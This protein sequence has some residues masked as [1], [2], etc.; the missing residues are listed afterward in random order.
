MG[1]TSE[2]DKAKINEKLINRIKKLEERAR[3]KR[4]V[5]KRSVIGAK[6]LCEQPF[7]LTYQSKRSGKRMWCL[8]EKRHLRIQFISFLK[9]LFY[10]ARLVRE[11]WAMGDFSLKYPLGLYPPT[12]PKLAE[13]VDLWG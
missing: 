2:E 5:E 6:R 1:I 12:V 4:V 9:N 10:E 8:S 7:N 11:R 3:R 13:P